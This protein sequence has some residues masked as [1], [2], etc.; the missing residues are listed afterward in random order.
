MPVVGVATIRAMR[1]A[2]ASAISV[3]AGKTLL[4]D[5]AAVVDAANAAG[6][7]IVGRVRVPRAASGEVIQ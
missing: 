7:A 4:I 5:G 3:D 1:E 6:V 2:G